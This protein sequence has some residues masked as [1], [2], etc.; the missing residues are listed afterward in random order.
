MRVGDVR[1][2]LWIVSLETAC[3]L[4]QWMVIHEEMER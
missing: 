4:M 3:I 1:T 2:A